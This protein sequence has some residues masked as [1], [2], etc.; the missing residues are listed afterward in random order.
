[1]KP[2]VKS[3][4][5]TACRPLVLAVVGLVMAGCRP[6]PPV[7]P[8]DTF[9]AFHEAV[10]GRDVKRAFGL[11][12]TRSRTA[13]EAGARGVAERSKGTLTAD[14]A[15][16]TFASSSKAASVL[17]IKVDAV[18]DESAV[19]EVHTCR[20]PLDASA[21][22]PK[23]EDMRERVTMVKEAQRWAIELPELVKP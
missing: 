1:M 21:A 5:W 11:L 2:F 7:T 15:A 3:L 22:C 6:G 4:G 17:S 16:L 13:A 14:A 19:L 9:R 18:S 10:R 12:S 8:E 23:D 20:R